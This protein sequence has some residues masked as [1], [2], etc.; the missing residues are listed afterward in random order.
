MRREAVGRLCLGG[1]GSGSSLDPPP[2][3]DGAYKQPLPRSRPDPGWKHCERHNDENTGL[4][5]AK[6]HLSQGPKFKLPAAG[7]HTVGRQR[8][9]HHKQQVHRWMHTEPLHKY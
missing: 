9:G 8:A 6:D 1:V 5:E 2:V 3:T 7:E 4:A